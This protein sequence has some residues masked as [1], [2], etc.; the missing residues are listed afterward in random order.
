MRHPILKIII[1]NLAFSLATIAT[2][3]E[4]PTYQPRPVAL[5]KD[6][7]YVLDDGSI[8]IVAG[9]DMTEL[10][11][12]FNALFIRTHPDF[13]FKMLLKGDSSNALAGITAGVSAFAP[14]SREA[15]SLDVRPFRQIYGYTPTDIRIARV[16]YNAPDH[17]HAPGI[18]INSTNPLPSLTVEQVARIFTTG[19]STGDLTHW[20]QLGV[21]G[22]WEQR[23]I[24][25]YGPRDDGSFASALRDAQMGGFP[26]TRRYEPLPDDAEILKAVA[27]DPYGIALVGFFDAKV[28]PP[29]V[30]IV[31]L[32]WK[33]G[34][35][36][37]T[38]SY[39]DVQA[40][41]YPFSP[42]LHL[43]V[44]RAPGK[45][46]DALMKEYARL[47]LSKEGQAIIAEGK[48]NSE[49]GYV[50]LSAHEVAE[51]LA[52]LE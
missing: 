51:E 27:Q 45:T 6:A 46:L 19:N 23:T 12:K 31:P 18:Y 1:L 9:D 3:Q 41:K 15:W 40:G 35:T 44:N 25:V 2:A 32:A 16:G 34:A 28:L 4:I 30:K 42:F 10:L 26:F 24:H 13:K 11:T 22:A 48:K 17:T 47:V 38:G 20:N 50:P 5:P 33:E 21:K 43:Y 7:P 39:E 14:M 29:Q 8:H 36:Y 37:S 52:K 49:K